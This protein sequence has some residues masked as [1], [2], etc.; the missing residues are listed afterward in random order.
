MSYENV[1][2]SH[3]VRGDSALVHDFAGENEERNGKNG[4]LADASEQPLGQ[5]LEEQDLVCHDKAG[6]RP[7]GKGEHHGHADG[8]EDQ[9]TPEKRHRHRGISSVS[10]T[11]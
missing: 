1:C 4:K 3:Q 6:E 5:H 7:E 8:H 10:F 9:E 11:R 2:K